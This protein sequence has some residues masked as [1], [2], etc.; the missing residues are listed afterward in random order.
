MSL[1]AGLT[2][3]SGFLVLSLTMARH[4]GRFPVLAGV[5]AVRSLRIA[6]FALLAAAFGLSIIAWGWRIGPVA[7]FGILTLLALLVAAL[8]SVTALRRKPRGR[9]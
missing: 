7:W 9:R 4:G 5:P 2:A 3:L 8:W 1:L 6:G